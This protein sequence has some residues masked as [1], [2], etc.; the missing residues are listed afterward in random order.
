MGTKAEIVVGR[1]QVEAHWDPDRDK[2]VLVAS[3]ARGDVYRIE[4][5]EVGRALRS[6]ILTRAGVR[7]HDSGWPWSRRY[8]A[9]ERPMRL[10][11]VLRDGRWSADEVLV[12][13][14]FE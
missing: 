10:V 2:F 8:V 7:E 6:D 9:A 4:L 14:S 5:N 3:T 1:A 12:L 13:T 11:G